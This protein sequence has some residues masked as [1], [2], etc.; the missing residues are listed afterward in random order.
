MIVTE[1][2][3]R[4]LWCPLSRCMMTQDL[5][6]VPLGLAQRIAV[7]VNRGMQNGQNIFV[8]TCIGAQCMLWSWAGGDD[9]YEYSNDGQERDG[10]EPIRDTILP[11]FRRKIPSRK[12]YCGLSHRSISHP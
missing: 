1:E 7:S 4:K 5:A 12:G 6:G 10:W 9:E 2:E 11:R 3:A 8:G